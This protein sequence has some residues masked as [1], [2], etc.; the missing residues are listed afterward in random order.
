MRALDATFVGLITERF[1]GLP[2]DARPKWGKMNR[3]QAIGHLNMTALY[4]LGNGPSF[5]FRGNLLTRH[6]FRPLLVNGWMNFP[7]NIKLPAPKGLTEMPPPPEGTVPEF[8]A[9]LLDFIQKR[10]QGLIESRIHPFFG[11]LTLKEWSKFQ[12]GHIRHHMLQFGIA[13]GI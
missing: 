11:P 10:D 12:V 9:N 7:H 4:V 8:R 13:D 1:N 5:N 2:V 6:V 3:N